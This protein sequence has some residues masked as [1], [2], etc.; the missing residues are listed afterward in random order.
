MLI[1]LAVKEQFVARK[2]LA[3]ADG[4]HFAIIPALFYPHYFGGYDE[5]ARFSWFD[6]A[7]YWIS[8]TESCNRIG[9]NGHV[10]NNIQRTG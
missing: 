4:N 1:A 7:C 8:G 5:E 6:N 2:S 10:I 3:L 9:T